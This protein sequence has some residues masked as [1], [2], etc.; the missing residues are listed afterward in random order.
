MNLIIGNTSQLSH[1]FPKDGFSKISA[2]NINFL[3][4]EKKI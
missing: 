4:L 2:R 3:N 1:F